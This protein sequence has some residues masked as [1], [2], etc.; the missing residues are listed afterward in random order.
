MTF[1]VAPFYQLLIMQF[2]AKDSG[3]TVP[4]SVQ[5]VLFE[6]ALKRNDVPVPLDVCSSGLNCLEDVKNTPLQLEEPQFKYA[7]PVTFGP[8]VIGSI[9]NSPCAHGYNLISNGAF[10][11]EELGAA[12][13]QSG[14]QVFRYQVNFNAHN[15]NAIYTSG[16]SV[17]PLG[18]ALN[19]IIRTQA[20]RSDFAVVGE[21]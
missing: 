16:G 8:N 13:L 19:Y 3:R 18:L 12:L 21:N 6:E 17:H 4:L 9:T 20:Q 15:S 2:K 11:Q 14:S 7:Q 1:L 5:I 10:S